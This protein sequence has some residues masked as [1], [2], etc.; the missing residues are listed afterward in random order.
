MIREVIRHLDFR[1]LVGG[2]ELNE[3][4][5]PDDTVALKVVS[6]GEL[7]IRLW[8]RC[9][10]DHD[11]QT[12]GGLTAFTFACVVQYVP[13]WKDF[14]YMDTVW[15]KALPVHVFAPRILVPR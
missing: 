10:L 2:H 6:H 7:E 14:I 13:P 8:Y 15:I 5:L 3:L 1:H 9:F 4:V 11:G 12:V